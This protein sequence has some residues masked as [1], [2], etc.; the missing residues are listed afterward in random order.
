MKGI[1]L[2]GGSGTR[3][4]PLTKVTSKQLLPVYDK[5]MIYYPLS[6]LMNADI[7]DILIISTPADTPRFQEL[8]G[9]GH[10]FGLHLQYKVQ[11]SPD[12]L[13]QAFIIGEEF[14]GK[15]DV[16]MILGDNIFAGHGLTKRLRAAV[17][18][19]EN[20][21]GASVFGYYV[22][23]PE[24]FGIVEFNEKG[25][26]ISIEEKPQKPKSNYC[27]TG[28]YFYDNH[29]VEYAKNLKPSARGELEITDLNRIYLEQGKLNVELLGQGFT[30]LDT[31]THESLADATNF[32]KTMEQHQHRKIACLEEIAY[33][34]GWISREELLDD[35]EELK[36]NQYG[37]YL[38]DVLNGKYVD[39]LS[40]NR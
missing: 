8:L 22:D 30:W 33:L 29:V 32:V 11:P 21:E 23:D 38:L 2:A 24:R 27:V 3:L 13:A 40:E 12:G 28:L 9:D 7:R 10:Q 36:K 4:Y 16:A 39:I 1:V 5:P 25:Q 18:R 31:G 17:K 20:G 37:Q 34:N 15:D 19:A 14:I 6:V 26:A 35:Y